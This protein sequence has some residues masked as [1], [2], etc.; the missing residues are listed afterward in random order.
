MMKAALIY[1]LLTCV[2]ADNP[3]CTIV[4]NSELFVRPGV[5]KWI[6]IKCVADF[7]SGKPF[8]GQFWTK[9]EINGLMGHE[10]LGAFR[11]ATNSAGKSQARM[12]PQN[13]IKAKYIGDYVDCVIFPV[14]DHAVTTG[15]KVEVIDS[16]KEMNG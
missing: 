9:C 1:T 11:G 7:V 13:A 3:I 15:F 4:N 8:V 12:P 16:E 2:W 10:D 5:V 14:D 6:D